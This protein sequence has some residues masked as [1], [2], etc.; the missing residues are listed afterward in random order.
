MS[1]E[2]LYPHVALWAQDEKVLKKNLGD[3][4]RVATTILEG[5]EKI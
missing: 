3:I 4:R 1:R 5:L 2:P